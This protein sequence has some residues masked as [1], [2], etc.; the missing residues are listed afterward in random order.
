MTCC[1]PGDL[2][3]RLIPVGR[4][5]SSESVAMTMMIS[6]A[7]SIEH[8]A[9]TWQTARLVTTRLCRP[10]QPPGFVQSRP[11][12]FLP[13]LPWSPLIRFLGAR[14]DGCNCRD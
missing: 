11:F 14:A 6:R 2:V 12:L 13:V 10:G 9:G 3:L 7:S 1:E 5:N 8:R 4:R